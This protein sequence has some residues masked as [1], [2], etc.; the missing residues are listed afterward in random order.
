M[1]ILLITPPMTQL[2]TP[3]PATAYLKGYLSEKFSNHSILQSDFSIELFH[4]VFSQKFL[5]KVKTEIDQSTTDGQWSG[6]IEYFRKHFDSITAVV[7]PVKRFLQGQDSS[8]AHRIATRKFFPEGPRFQNA[9]RQMEETG[10]LDF[11]FGTMGIQDKAK[12]FATLFI[13]EITDVITNTIDPR[14]SLSHYAEKISASQADFSVIENSLA[15]VTL[16]DQEISEMTMKKMNHLNPQLIVLTVPFP[17]NLYGALRIAR[18]VR[19]HFPQ[20]QI[21][22]GGGYV[23]TELRSLEDERVFDYVDFITLDDGELPLERIIQRQEDENVKYVRTFLKSGEQVVF[24]NDP[25]AQNIPFEKTGS[26]TYSGLDLSLYVSILENLNPMHRIWSDTRWNKITAA[27]G[28]YWK[29][30]S[31]CDVSLDYIGRYEQAK[32]AT[33]VDRMEKMIQETGFSGFH[34]V[35]EAAPPAVLK[36][37]AQ[38]I[39]K[40]GLNLSWWG[41]IRFDKAFDQNLTALLAKA[42]CIAVSGGIEVASDRLLKLMNKGVTLDQVARVTKAFNTSGIL[43]HA[44]LMYGFP[45]QTVQETIDSLEVVRK[46]FQN[47]CID[48][49]FWHRFSATIHSPIGKNPEKFGI[50]ILSSNEKRTKKLFAQNDLEFSDPTGVDHDFLGKG[51][52]KALYNFMLGMGLDEDVRVWFDGDV[53]KAKA[54]LQLEAERFDRV[55]N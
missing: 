9:I 30:C 5:Y 21:A 34:F 26:P 16:I 17:G 20:I 31:F 4:R 19:K 27:H 54:S 42:G 25:S 10:Y 18:T 7:E 39:L 33:I 45:T 2:N 8:L 37:V 3:Y 12:Y 11:A 38:E 36:S 48:S 15:Q 29:K 44:Y 52:N 49:A 23:N 50:E 41:N 1:R 28:C 55:P 24:Q 14:F 46:L 35:D 22:M 32:A 6:S 47:G 43:V 40:R 13:E 51:L 53:P